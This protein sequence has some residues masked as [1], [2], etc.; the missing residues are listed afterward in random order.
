MRDWAGFKA[1]VDELLPRQYEAKIKE[2][3]T[4]IDNTVSA[5]LRGQLN[6]CIILGVYYAI[7]LTLA[8]L[9]FGMLIGFGAGVLS[10]VPFVGVLIGVIFGLVVAFFQF[11]GDIIRIGIVGAVF[12]VGQIAEGN[13]LT[14][15]IVG[16]KIG[17]HPAW[18]IFGMLAG[19]SLLGLTGIILAVPLT[20]IINVLIQFAVE[21]Y[22]KSDYYSGGKAE[23]RRQEKAL[24]ELKDKTEAKKTAA[25]KRAKAK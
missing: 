22:E 9:N 23:I 10:F 3:V 7:G 17:V 14:P 25:K 18:L 16:D 5:F 4:K 15:K 2:Q 1:K 12:A 11:D 8:G 19:G 24:Q 21:E 13:F 6:V 20:A